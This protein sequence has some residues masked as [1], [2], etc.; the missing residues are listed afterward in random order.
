M[1]FSVSVVILL[2]SFANFG[3]ARLTAPEFQNLALNLCRVSSANWAA[4]CVKGKCYEP[5]LGM[6]GPTRLTGHLCESANLFDLDTQYESLVTAPIRGLGGVLGGASPGCLN[7]LRR[8]TGNIDNVLTQSANGLG[9]ACTVADL[10]MV[11]NFAN[12]DVYKVVRGVV[13]LYG[14]AYMGPNMALRDL[15]NVFL[16]QLDASVRAFPGMY[17]TP[18]KLAGSG[19]SA[20]FMQQGLSADEWL[21]NRAVAPTGLTFEALMLLIHRVQSHVEHAIPAAPRPVGFYQKYIRTLIPKSAFLDKADKML[22]A[23]NQTAYKLGVALNGLIV[24]VMDMIALLEADVASAIDEYNALATPADAR[25][26]ELVGI[27]TTA[28]NWLS[29]D[30]TNI[31]VYLAYLRSNQVAKLVPHIYRKWNIVD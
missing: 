7:W 15:D 18:G 22:A 29:D 6:F 26:V 21:L 4:T 31:L 10:S 2:L 27:V 13:D 30:C 23:K 12:N 25:G 8:F 14:L 24:L 1:R 17:R 9:V 5:T 28:K 19:T 20:L 3:K 16:A 11:A